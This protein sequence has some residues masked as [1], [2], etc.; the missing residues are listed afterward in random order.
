MVDY[1]AFILALFSTPWT[2]GQS[3]LPAEGFRRMD[4]PQSN[5]LRL[6]GGMHHLE[7]TDVFRGTFCHMVSSP[8]VLSSSPHLLDLMDF[9]TNEAS[10]G[11]HLLESAGEVMGPLVVK[12]G[13]VHLEIHSP[14]SLDK[15][16]LFSQGFLMALLEEPHKVPLLFLPLAG[17]L[18]GSDI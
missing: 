9:R 4:S 6:N 11:G 16:G 14:S 5:D 15:V 12:V 7:K 1:N 2:E 17:M 3:H 13:E 18:F 10:R 8:E